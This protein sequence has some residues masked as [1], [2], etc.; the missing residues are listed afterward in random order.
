MKEVVAVG[1]AAHILNVLTHSENSGAVA[2]KKAR[3]KP[4]MGSA[5]AKLNHMS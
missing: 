3:M 4:W 5:P 2:I 1:A